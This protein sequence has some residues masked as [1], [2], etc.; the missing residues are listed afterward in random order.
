M[1]VAWP[2]IDAEARHALTPKTFGLIPR[3][4][5]ETLDPGDRAK[6]GFEGQGG[7]VGERFWVTVV[8]RRSGS[9]LGRVEAKLGGP[10]A[11]DYPEGSLVAFEPKHVLDASYS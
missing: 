3:A 2:L 9:Y 11:A 8:R 10:W 5:R 1:P 7:S 4:E 6:I